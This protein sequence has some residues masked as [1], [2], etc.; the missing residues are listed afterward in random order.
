MHC[1]SRERCLPKHLRRF[2]SC[3]QRT[4]RDTSRHGRTYCKCCRIDNRRHS[5]TQNTRRTEQKLTHKLLTNKH[6]IVKWLFNT[7]IWYEDQKFGRKAIPRCPRYLGSAEFPAVRGRQA[8]LLLLRQVG[9]LRIVLEAAKINDDVTSFIGCCAQSDT[10]NYLFGQ[11]MHNAAKMIML[12]WQRD[13]K[14]TLSQLIL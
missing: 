9:I 3:R 7:A 4:A 11:A 8:G 1:T 6:F 2:P 10:L 13:T 5:A 12:S 14:D